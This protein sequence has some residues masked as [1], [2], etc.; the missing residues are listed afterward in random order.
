M[1]KSKI[2]PVAFPVLS[3]V[4]VSISPPVLVH[5]ESENVLPENSSLEYEFKV[6]STKETTK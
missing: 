5:S 1:I 6:Y 3:K 2:D 4:Q